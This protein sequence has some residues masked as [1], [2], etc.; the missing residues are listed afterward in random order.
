MTVSS[1]LQQTTVQLK[2]LVAQLEAMRTTHRDPHAG[3]VFQAA[4]EELEDIRSHLEERLA[5]I[6]EMEPQYR[7]PQPV[8]TQLREKGQPPLPTPDG[9]PTEE[10][11]VARGQ[12]ASGRG[13]GHDS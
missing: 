1:R 2:A 9:K 6:Q 11:P 8:L 7:Q 12:R 10:R 13:D 3:E 4:V 5:A